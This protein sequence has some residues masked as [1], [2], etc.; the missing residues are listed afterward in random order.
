VL[1]FVLPSVFQM[2]VISGLS[3]GTVFAANTACILMPC[4][5]SSKPIAVLYA[6]GGADP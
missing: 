4:W 6:A 1:L 2:A 5:E 3:H